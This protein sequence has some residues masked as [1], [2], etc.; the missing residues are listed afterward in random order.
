MAAEFDN[1]NARSYR[2]GD[3][4]LESEKRRLTRNGAVIRLSHKPLQVLLHLI[5]HRERVVARQELLDTF[6]DSKDVYDDSL[7]KSIGAIRK[8]LDEEASGARFIETHYGEGYRYVGPLEEEA[9]ECAPATLE[10]EKTRGVRIVI[11]EEDTP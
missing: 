10:I 9:I 11:E 7:R 2:L 3:Y 4:R 8:A 1:Q 6:W 5:E